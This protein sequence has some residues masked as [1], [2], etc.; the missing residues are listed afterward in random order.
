MAHLLD[1]K[2]WMQLLQRS[3]WYVKS[4]ANHGIKMEKR[5]RILG[6]FYLAIPVGS[7][8]G[9]LLGGHLAPLYGWRFPGETPGNGLPDVNVG[10]IDQLNGIIQRS[11]TAPV[12]STPVG[13]G[14]GIGNNNR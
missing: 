2:G 9:Y 3:G 6:V 5:G 13:P 11:L 10:S 8:A 4:P 12:I 1:Q 7:A 14:P